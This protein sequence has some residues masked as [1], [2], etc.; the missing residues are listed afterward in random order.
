MTRPPPHRRKRTVPITLTLASSIGLLVAIAVFAE[1]Y[2]GFSSGRRNTLALLNEKSVMMISVIE[3]GLRN[4]LDP[5]ADQLAHLQNLVDVGLLD[6][7][8]REELADVIAGALAAAPQISGISYW[9]SGL[10]MTVAILEDNE[11]PTIQTRDHSRHPEIQAIVE[12]AKE[13]G[14]TFWGD[15][16][17]DGVTLVNVIR[18]IYRDGLYVGTASAAVTMP[19]LSRLMERVG[20]L[21]EATAFIQ[22]GDDHVLAHPFLSTDHPDLS[23]A[24]PVVRLARVG[25]MPLAHIAAARP[26]PGFEGAAAAGV[27]VSEI[28]V[29]GDTHVLF[30]H[31]IRDYG[32]VPW[33]IGAHVPVDLINDELARLVLSAVAGVGVFLLAVIA[34]I[35]LG[36]AIAR[37]VKRSAAGA[38]Q[39]AALELAEV[40]P[41]GPSFI[42]E[43]NDQADAFNMMLKGLRWFETYVP[44]SLVNRLI[45]SDDE[46]AAASR[47]QDVTLMF[48][49]IVGFTTLSETLPA[50]TV[51]EMLNHHLGL[52]GTCVEAEGG[53]IDKFIGD[54]VMAFWG[55]PDRQDDHPARAARAVQ[56]IRTALAADNEARIASG[57]MPIRV[58]IGVHTGRVV[59]GNIGA[60]GRINYTIVGDAVN[61]GQRIEALAKEFDD[62]MAAAT[63][64][65]SAATISRLGGEVVPVTALGAYPVRGRSKAVELF[66]LAGEE[67]T[68][69]RPEV[70]E[71]ART[72][73]P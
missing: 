40:N 62:G 53:T 1:L 7:D 2:L 72:R 59:V 17:F 73:A 13:T 23:A 64:L 29:F 5:A 48:T 32:E 43:L 50:N 33:T 14:R 31:R 4:H 41:L 55:A 58:R 56:A 52:V 60:P 19:E 54:S 36:H 45:R 51:A 39:I 67:G 15:L 10:H 6:P 9:D 49:D 47:E 34:A 22:Y 71:S 30:T 20:E 37:P 25:D 63:I 21:F 70:S 12:R 68:A 46:D 28:D 27:T 42:R 69:V 38:A 35:A 61:T 3:T 16:A 65:F 57:Q 24:T 26:V 18:P 44:R 11:R 8:D 66:K